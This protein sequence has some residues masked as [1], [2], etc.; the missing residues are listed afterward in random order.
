V[1]T[2]PLSF[3]RYE[4]LTL[5]SFT[6]RGTLPMV[7]AVTL[8]QVHPT[9]ITNAVRRL[10]K[11][12]LA[13]RQPHPSDGRAVLIH[14]TEQGRRLVAEATEQCRL[15]RPAWAAATAAQDVVL[16]DPRPPLRGGRLRLIST[17]KGAS[18]RR[19]TMTSGIPSA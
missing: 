8:L 5:L 15:V 19:C 10:Q 2:A 17:P 16:S 6:R 14:I 1:T 13:R 12:G 18:C 4:L 3:G 9:S 7:Q 11:A